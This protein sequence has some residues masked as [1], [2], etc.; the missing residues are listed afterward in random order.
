M[1]AH[2]GGCTCAHVSVSACV[3]ECL[4]ARERACA[5]ASAHAGSWAGAHVHTHTS[6][7]PASMMQWLMQWQCQ[8]KE[9]HFH[10]LVFGRATTARKP[11]ALN[12]L[13]PAAYGRFQ[14]EYDPGW[15]RRRGPRGSCRNGRSCDLPFLRANAL[16]LGPL[17]LAPLVLAP[18]LASV[19][20]DETQRVVRALSARCR[21]VSLIFSSWFA[22]I[23][24]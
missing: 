11:L 1:C 2:A 14:K 15:Q 24:F 5:L 12:R 19:V 4:R 22:T 23:L 13:L 8:S 21:S 20:G 6:G 16:V 18:L 7:M 10:E 9:R 17:V 3:R